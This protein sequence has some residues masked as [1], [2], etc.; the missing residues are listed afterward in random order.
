MVTVS[1]AERYKTNTYHYMQSLNPTL[2]RRIARSL[3]A[4]LFIAALLL[5]SSLLEIIRS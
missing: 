3:D 2:K 4:V 1:V 5:L